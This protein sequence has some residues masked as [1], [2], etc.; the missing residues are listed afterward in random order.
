M[1]GS[2]EFTNNMSGMTKEMHDGVVAAF[3]ALSKWRDEI[4]AVN[5]RCLKKVLDQ[6]STTARSMGWPDQAVRMTREHLEKASK[7]QTEIIDQIM[8]GWRQQMK[9]PPAAMGIPPS[10]AG[11]IAGLSGGGMPAFDPMAP[12]AFWMQAA[13]AWQRTWMPDAARYK[14]RSH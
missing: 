10:F 11:Q 12:W 13:E 1:A 4:E 7:A 9:A 6:T 5:E 8:E 14:N 3:D 2:S